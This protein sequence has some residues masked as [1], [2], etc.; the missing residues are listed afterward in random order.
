MK[1]IKIACSPLTGHIF[2]GYTLKNNTWA[3]GKQDV[4]V[5]ALVAVAEH[6]VKF[7]K[8]VELTCDGK[9]EYRI[10]VELIK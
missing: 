9:V 4:T 2:A 10:T 5:D 8:P 6:V 7:G 3:A 1:P